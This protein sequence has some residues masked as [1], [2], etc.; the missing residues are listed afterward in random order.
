M[1]D[2]TFPRNEGWAMIEAVEALIDLALR[3][4][5]SPHDITTK[6][7][8]KEK[9]RGSAVVLAKKIFCWQDWSFTGCF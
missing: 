4:D 6:S 3:E 2:V 7:L 5:L 1:K 8:I 9:D